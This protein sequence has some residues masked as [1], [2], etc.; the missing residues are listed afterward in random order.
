MGIDE[1][2]DDSDTYTAGLPLAPRFMRDKHPDM[3]QAEGE[4][5]VDLL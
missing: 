1:I 2:D 5:V 3:S 4:D